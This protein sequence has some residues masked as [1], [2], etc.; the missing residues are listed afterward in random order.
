MEFNLAVSHKIGN[1]SISRP[2][3]EIPGYIPKD[4]PLYY[5]VTCSAIFIAALFIIVKNWNQSRCPFIDKWI[6]KMWFLYTVTHG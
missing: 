5:K 6:K 4:V 2:T 3:Y 1:S